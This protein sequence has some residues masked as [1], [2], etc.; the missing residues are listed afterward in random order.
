MLEESSLNDLSEEQL[1][2]LFYLY[3]KEKSFMNEIGE[4]QC[5]SNSTGTVVVDKLIK[6][7]LVYRQ[8]SDQDRRQVEV[9][10]SEKGK[11]LLEQILARRHKRLEIFLSMMNSEEIEIVNKSLNI[12]GEKIKVALEN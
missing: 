7:E 9:Y 2:V 4:S 3:Y 10:I 11:E 12:L 6:K 8:R 5:I 1:K